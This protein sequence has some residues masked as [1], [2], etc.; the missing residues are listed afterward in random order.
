MQGFVMFGTGSEPVSFTFDSVP[1]GTYQEPAYTV[2]FDF[3][4]DYT[5]S[6]PIE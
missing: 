4:A 1:A 5:V 3:Q 2:G 6:F